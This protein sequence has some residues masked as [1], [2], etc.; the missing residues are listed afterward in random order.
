MKTLITG[1]AGFIGSHL[2]EALLKKGHKVNVVDNLS[3]G[4]LENIQHLRDLS[5][6][7]AQAGKADFSFVEGDIL[8]EELMES[9]IAEVDEIYLD[10]RA[11]PKRKTLPAHGFRVPCSLTAPRRR[12]PSPSSYLRRCAVVRRRR[13]RWDCNP[14]FFSLVGCPV[15]V[16][17]S[18][19]RSAP[20][21][22]C[23]NPCKTAAPSGARVERL[24]SH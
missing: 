18:A 3:T 17:V 1:G 15:A 21:E 2:T 10:N 22:R 19:P 20:S 9:L 16:H 13:D 8:D 12:P 23:V 6:C 4:R 5:A 7:I 11:K 14:T 24:A